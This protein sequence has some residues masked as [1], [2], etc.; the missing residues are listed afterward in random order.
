MIDKYRG[1]VVPD[2]PGNGLDAEIADAVRAATDSM[3]RYKVH[4]ALAASMDLARLAN[5]YV[6]ERQP[7]AQAKDPEKLADLDETLATLARS[8]TA[9]CALFE[10]VAPAKMA[11]LAGYLGLEGVPTLDGAVSIGLAGRNVTKGPP[12]FPRVEPSWAET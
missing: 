3:T 7:W 1:G 12:L 11:D 4:E 2:A 9:L 10:P 5:G 8:L 6:E